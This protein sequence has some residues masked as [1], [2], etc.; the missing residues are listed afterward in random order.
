MLGDLLVAFS[1]VVHSIVCCRILLNLR[2]AATPRGS[3]TV[4][5]SISLQ[6]EVTP[7]QGTSLAEAIRLDTFVV[8]DD[9][10]NYCQEADGEFVEWHS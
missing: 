3:S 6:F 1:R 9:G 4:L 10:E 8:R 2:Q 5:K 7:E